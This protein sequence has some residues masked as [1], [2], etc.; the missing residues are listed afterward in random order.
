MVTEPAL[1]PIQQNTQG[2]KDVGTT[3]GP[4]L[5]GSTASRGP[6]SYFSQVR[7]SIGWVRDKGEQ[8]ILVCPGLFQL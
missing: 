3:V 6:L 5:G 2:P 7:L 8:L 1:E 4:E